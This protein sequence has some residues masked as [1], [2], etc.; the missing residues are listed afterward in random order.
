MDKKNTLPAFLC[1][2]APL[3]E[4]KATA[5]VTKPTVPK[6]MWRFEIAE[7]IIIIFPLCNVYKQNVLAKRRVG[8]FSEI[9]CAK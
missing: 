6:M 1:S 8:A 2:L 9:D 7:I 4:N 5:P 3:A